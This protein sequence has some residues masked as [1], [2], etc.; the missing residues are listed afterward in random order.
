[1]MKQLGLTA[2]GAGVLVIVLLFATSQ[3]H[4][5]TRAEILEGYTTELKK[6]YND[7]SLNP[8]VTALCQIIA[9]RLHSILPDTSQLDYDLDEKQN[10]YF[11]KIAIQLDLDKQEGL[12]HGA[13]S[14]M[15]ARPKSAIMM[16]LRVGINGGMTVGVLG[17]PNKRQQNGWQR[18]NN[19]KLGFVVTT[20]ARTPQVNLFARLS[21]MTERE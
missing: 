9:R 19:L 14:E 16:S 18:S 4:A 1:M 12:S 6:A 15:P 21:I 13:F 20:I 5:I 8:A 10:Q 17:R 11:E 3:A 7:P 2:I